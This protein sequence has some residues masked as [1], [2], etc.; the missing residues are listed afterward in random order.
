MI[1]DAL[2]VGLQFPGEGAVEEGREEGVEPAAAG[3]LLNPAGA[4]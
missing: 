4:R 3:G 2:P 1:L